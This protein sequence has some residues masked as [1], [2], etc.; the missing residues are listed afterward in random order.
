VLGYLG[1]HLWHVNFHYLVGAARPVFPYKIPYELVSP[2][3]RQPSRCMTTS[4]I[5]LKTTGRS[6]RQIEVIN[7]A[8]GKTIAL[9]VEATPGDIDAAV[10]GHQQSPALTPWF[11]FVLIGSLYLRST[12]PR[13]RTFQE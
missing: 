3:R 2:K 7:P 1:S 4:S 13:A 11:L 8:T 12:L 6:E 5:A 10:M 9:S